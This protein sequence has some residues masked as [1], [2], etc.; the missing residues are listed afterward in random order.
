MTKTNNEQKT[1]LTERTG[2]TEQSTLSG[3]GTLI[4]RVAIGLFGLSFCERTANFT[5][6]Y[7]LI[8][9]FTDQIG[10]S[11]SNS[12]L[13]LGAVL[14]ANSLFYSISGAISDRLLGLRYTLLVGLLLMVPAYLSLCIVLD[15]TDFGTDGLI[16]NSIFFGALAIQICSISLVRLS[17]FN[18]I[19]HTLPEADTRSE[20]L[21]VL[22]YWVESIAALMASIIAGT[23]IQR[24]GWTPIFSVLTIGMTVSGAIIFMNRHQLYIPSSPSQSIQP[25]TAGFAVALLIAC[26]FVMISFPTTA[27]I[28][29]TLVAIG[30]IYF[31]YRNRDQFRT[32]KQKEYLITFTI[33]TIASLLFMALQ[34]QQWSS[35]VLF[36]D[37]VV[38][39]AVFGFTLHP[40][41]FQS[42][43][44]I[45]LVVCAPAVAA[46][47]DKRQF[48]DAAARLSAL[49][50]KLMVS[51]ALLMVC[52]VVLFTSTFF[53]D[54][55][56]KIHWS[57]L[58]IALVIAGPAE[59]F[60]FPIVFNAITKN[61]PAKLASTMTGIHFTCY[62]VSGYAAGVLASLAGG[63]P[64]EQGLN[65]V[66]LNYR[67]FLG[68]V[69]T[70][71]GVFVIICIGAAM[72]FASGKYL[73]V[74]KEN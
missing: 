72:V 32:V 9:V 60:I 61:A 48:S 25:V 66:V 40:S 35:L 58:V 41:H 30:V 44:P 59:L 17:G 26:A 12:A 14:T 73:G 37:R 29:S 63:V 33:V 4:N 15:Y 68:L 24:F 5:I 18:L 28:A 13:V 19:K 46:L 45:M 62:A 47:L 7:L 50:R 55:T 31:V 16:V 64:S 20:K 2:A 65:A 34:E 11:D 57:W 23:F 43:I 39:R 42:I 74:L 21:Y 10:L 36:A 1:A 8:L 53:T 52:F 51:Y 3:Q 69:G 67:E 54:A 6:K 27:G 22:Y 38:D 49:L 70:T 71:G 56:N